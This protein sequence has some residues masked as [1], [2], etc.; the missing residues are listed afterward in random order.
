MLSKKPTEKIRTLGIAEVM[1]VDGSLLN[2]ARSLA[3]RAIFSLMLL[4]LPDKRQRRLVPHRRRSHFPSKR[5]GLIIHNDCAR[6]SVETESE[7]REGMGHGLLVIVWHQQVAKAR[8]RRECH[9]RSDRARRM[10]DV[11]VPPSSEVHEM[12]AEHHAGYHYAHRSE[13]V[14]SKGSGHNAALID[15]E[16]GRKVK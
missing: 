7:R 2:Y 16:C 14:S 9:S 12:E 4:T 15:G 8:T 11:D 5:D 6:P 13:G 3:L 10:S 1:M